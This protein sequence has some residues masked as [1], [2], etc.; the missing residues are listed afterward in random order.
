MM[1]RLR[2]YQLFADEYSCADS[3]ADGR[4]HTDYNSFRITV[5]LMNLYGMNASIAERR[6]CCWRGQSS[7]GSVV[8]SRYVW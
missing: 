2:V 8:L 4:R 6:S 3:I 7:D 5:K 1:L